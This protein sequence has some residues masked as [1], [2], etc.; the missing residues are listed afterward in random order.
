MIN[1]TVPS[2]AGTKLKYLNPLGKGYAFWLRLVPA[3]LAAS[4]CAPLVQAGPILSLYGSQATAIVASGSNSGAVITYPSTATVG[5][6]VEFPSGTL[7]V[8]PAYGGAIIVGVNIDVGQQNILFTYNGGSGE[9]SPDTFNGYV[10][11]FANAPTITGVQLDPSS[12]Y[13]SGQVG[14]GFTA[15]EITVNVQGLPYSNTSVID[16]DV[17]LAPEPS[18]AILMSTAL[19]AMAFVIRRRSLLGLRRN[20]K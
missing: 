11:D 13:T 12:T 4:V 7:Q 2:T 15:N 6:G 20:S 14:L 16:V 5:A 17:T 10:L 9:F 1:H 8:L 3:V 18:S 19:F